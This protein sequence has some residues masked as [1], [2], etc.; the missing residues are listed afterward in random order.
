MAKKLVRLFVVVLVMCLA[1]FFAVFMADFLAV[2]L[3]GFLPVCLGEGEPM[4]VRGGVSGWMFL[5]S[6]RLNLRSA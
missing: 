4:V 1:S 6:L 5:H 3:A 2:C